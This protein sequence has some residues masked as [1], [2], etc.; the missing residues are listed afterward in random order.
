MS[1]F[2]GAGK[3]PQKFDAVVRSI[4]AAVLSLTLVGAVTY[5][6]IV[7][8]PGTRLSGL[9][10]VLV[11]WAGIVVGF[12]FGGHSTASAFEEA[13]QIVVTAVHETNGHKEKK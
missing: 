8:A 1:F 3:T 5:L 2:N 11:G 7:A 6:S 13:K 12:Y 4:T 10:A 9:Q